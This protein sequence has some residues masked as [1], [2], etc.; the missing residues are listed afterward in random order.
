MWLLG[1]YAVVIRLLF[2]GYFVVISWLF[3]DYFRSRKTRNS[4][5]QHAITGVTRHTGP[6]SSDHIAP[7]LPNLRLLFRVRERFGNAGFIRIFGW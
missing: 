1:G 5:Y 3:R 6:P 4:C 7:N 2:R